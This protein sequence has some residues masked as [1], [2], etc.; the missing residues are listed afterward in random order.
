MT[1]RAGSD[2]PDVAFQAAILAHSLKQ[3]EALLTYLDQFESV[4]PGRNGVNYYRASGLIGLGRHAEAL[5]ALD[6]EERRNQRRLLPVIVLRACVASG[7]GRLD[8][9]R[10]S[11]VEVLATR[12][13][14]V[15]FVSHSGLLQ[16]FDRL[17]AQRMSC[18]MAI[19]SCDHWSIVCSRPAWP[20]TISSIPIESRIPRLRS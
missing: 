3:Y 1:L 18:R 5:L 16:L 17:W 11:L 2:S 10:A 7:L 19:P 20:R 6:E 15:D 13:S 14:E 12:L 9:L 8:D 4:L